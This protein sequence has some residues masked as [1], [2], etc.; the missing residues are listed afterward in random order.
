MINNSIVGRAMTLRENWRLINVKVGATP[1][2][3]NRANGNLA[4]LSIAT[5]NYLSF[6]VI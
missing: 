2:E 3:I 1:I 5:D 4:F 6:A